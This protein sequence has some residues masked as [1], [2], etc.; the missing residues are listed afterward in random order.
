MYD[1]F[2][3]AFAMAPDKGIA[4]IAACNG[5][6]R[7]PFRTVRAGLEIAAGLE[8]SAIE[9]TLGPPSPRARK[10]MAGRYQ[11]GMGGTLEIREDA[12]LWMEGK[13]YPILACP[14]DRL[15]IRGFPIP[16][17]TTPLEPISRE[18]GQSA[19]HLRLCLRL[20]RRIHP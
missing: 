8:P 15:V 6:W 3:A 2:G 18:P 12:T 17:P 10:T 9:E 19:E 11:D 14:D 5:T 16:W 4:A 1:G 13:T 7:C 20:W